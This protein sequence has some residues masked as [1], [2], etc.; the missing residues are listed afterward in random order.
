MSRF[1]MLVCGIITFSVLAIFILQSVG[2][3]RANSN[4]Q[5]PRKCFL[6]VIDEPMLAAGVPGLLKHV[7]KEGD[8][9][10][11]DVF[12]AQLDEREAHMKLHVAKLELDVANKQATNTVQ[13]EYAVKKKDVDK[14]DFDVAQEAYN[15]VPNSVSL[16]E[17]RRRRLQYEASILSIKNAQNDLSIAKLEER[18][19]RGQVEAAEMQL[20]RH[21]VPAQL[22][23]KVAEVFRQV[24]EWVN[25]GD[26]IVRV[27]QLDRLYVEGYV[28]ASKYGPKDILGK[29]CTV[30][31]DMPRNK[32]EHFDTTITF[33]DDNIETTDE[34]RVRAEIENSKVTNGYLVV[35]GLPADMVIHF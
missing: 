18:V 19:V 7:A 5:L 35:P 2:Q 12:V 33:V 21:H 16:T 17:I 13:I 6:S 34:F 20:E 28:D 3:E 22:D 25:A 1:T 26:P 29:R 4:Y 11:A 30:L 32:I 24:G 15:K 8:L 14:A 10:T 27:R 23:G 31:V 9:V